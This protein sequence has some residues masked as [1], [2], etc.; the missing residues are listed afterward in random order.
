MLGSFTTL[1]NF[2]DLRDSDYN[3]LRY[4][5]C[6]DFHPA[7]IGNTFLD[8]YLGMMNLLGPDKLMSDY[9]RPAAFAVKASHDAKPFLTQASVATKLYGEYNRWSWVL[10]P[11]RVID[12]QASDVD[13]FSARRQRRLEVLF[14]PTTRKV[15]ISKKGET[16]NNSRVPMAQVIP[17]DLLFYRLLCLFK[18]PDT[19]AIKASLPYISGLGKLQTREHTVG[20]LTWSRI[21]PL[22]DSDSGNS[23]AGPARCEVAVHVISTQKDAHTQVTT[24]R[25]AAVGTVDDEENIVLD[26]GPDVDDWER[27]DEETR[28]IER[29]RASTDLT[30]PLGCR[31]MALWGRGRDGMPVGDALALDLGEHVW[32]STSAKVSSDW[33]PRARSDYASCVDGVKIY[34][35]GGRRLEDPLCNGKTMIIC[36]DE[37]IEYDTEMDTFTLLS[38]SSSNQV[39]DPSSSGCISNEPHV[40]HAPLAC[41]GATLSHIPATLTHHA[42]LITYGGV[43]SSAKSPN[44][45]GKSRYNGLHVFDLADRV[46]VAPRAAGPHPPRLC[47]HTAVVA[48]PLSD[49]VRRRIVLYGGLTDE[50]RT[51]LGATIAVPS[52]DVY[53]LTVTTS[54]ALR[55][56]E[57]SMAKGVKPIGRSGHSAVL[58]RERFM[59][60]YGGAV[61]KPVMEVL[62]R[63]ISKVKAPSW[64][65]MNELW[66]LNLANSMWT[67]LQPENDAGPPPLFAH[68]AAMFNNRLYIV[69]GRLSTTIKPITISL[70]VWMTDFGTPPAP[71]EPFLSKRPLHDRITIAWV[72]PYRRQPSRRIRVE[73]REARERGEIRPD[74]DDGW[75][76]AE[77][78]C[79]DGP[80]LDC[81]ITGGLP[82]WLGHRVGDPFSLQPSMAYEIRIAAANVRFR[83]YA[84]SATKDHIAVLR[85][86]T[87]H[88]RFYPQHAALRA[89][90]PA[91]VTVA[92]VKA[93]PG[94]VDPDRPRSLRLTWHH[95]PINN[96]SDVDGYVVHARASLRVA[97]HATDP[98]FSTPPIVT[99]WVK[100]WAG[101]D[102]TTDLATLFLVR[103]PEVIAAYRAAMRRAG[104]KEADDGVADAGTMMQV[105][106]R[107]RDVDVA[108]EFRVA[109]LTAVGVG[110]PSY[111]TRA[112]TVKYKTREGAG[113]ASMAG[114]NIEKLGADIRASVAKGPPMRPDAIE[115]LIGP[116]PWERVAVPLP[117]TPKTDLDEESPTFTMGGAASCLPPSPM[118]GSDD[119]VLVAAPAR[120]QAR[121]KK[122]RFAR[123]AE[124]EEGPKKKRKRKTS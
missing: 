95:R 78:R 87:G 101:C 114:V 45:A 108:W 73:I 119:M 26:F 46:W 39:Q 90:M 65:L 34:I 35:F 76:I 109:A 84:L 10:R 56:E 69:G 123:A 117:S 8:D 42:L 2:N 49:G 24:T 32:K 17:S 96:G 63:G 103:R 82:K 33:R 48:R 120:L 3:D 111:P 59:I 124:G 94:V 22:A 28:R 50:R 107:M 41:H 110:F 15:N 72:D 7:C 54:G 4:S 70:G 19:R 43:F 100:V 52:G 47:S 21:D 14:D 11:W 86:R 20:T 9:P 29:I 79:F 99:D 121:S 55:W 27:E 44:A 88:G 91:S 71:C 102:A 23:G 83:Q 89:A 112:V 93:N 67:Q 105:R 18:I 31:L 37:L 104:V 92:P 25:E 60:V 16:T 75:R 6:D 61:V 38:G 106:W 118:S 62:G 77:E 113:I 98:P 115:H 40:P 51:S 5:D 36:Y 1:F 74:D 122:G 57:K 13:L 68:A 12:R 81:T 116:R 97:T 85:V 66:V 30:P 80:G 53:F 64:Q 58:F